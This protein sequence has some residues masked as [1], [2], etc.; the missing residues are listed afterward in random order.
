MNLNFKKKKRKIVRNAPLTVLNMTPKKY[1]MEI[2]G[3]P[4]RIK[5]GAKTQLHIKSKISHLIFI[6]LV[7]IRNYLL[8]SL[9]QESKKE[10]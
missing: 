9:Q 5:T 4:P 3:K 6:F 1:E 8:V 7:T 10:R 2:T